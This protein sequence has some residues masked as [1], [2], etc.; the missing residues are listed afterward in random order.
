M[1]YIV[2]L[3]ILAAVDLLAA[4]SP[5]PNFVLVSQSAA[6]RSRRYAGA[7]VA[8]FVVSNLIWCLAVVLGLASLFKMAPWLYTSVK[9][10]GGLY[11]VFLGVQL[12]RSRDA[13]TALVRTPRG[14]RTA[15]LRG[16]LTNL[17]NP[18]SV[19]YFGS[20]FAVFLSPGTPT[21]VQAVAVAIVLTNTVLWYGTVAWLFSNVR[22]QRLYS[23]IQR[24]LNRIAGSLMAAFGARLALVRD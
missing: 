10:L 8:G 24:P 14:S 13:A 17:G 18:K 12:W 9:L 2:L 3:T 20:I 23:A 1:H 15:I 7:V 22:V 19:V 6:H 5:G 16:I 21:W 4:I 11:L